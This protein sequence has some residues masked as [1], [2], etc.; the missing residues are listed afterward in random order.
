MELQVNTSNQETIRKVMRIQ[1]VLQKTGLSKTQLY[2]MMHD[3]AF[4]APA[5]L[6]QRIRAWDS[7]EVESWLEE[8]FAKR[9]N[10]S[11]SDASRTP[12]RVDQ[13]KG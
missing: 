9:E 6:S 11:V 1:S 4:P 3:G 2:R 10:R 5:S 8:R 7:L 12:N 13:K